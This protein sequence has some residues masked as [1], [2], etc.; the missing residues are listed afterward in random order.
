M[1]PAITLITPTYRP[2][3]ERFAFQRESLERCGIDVEHVA[4]VHSED[5]EL[6]Q[7][8]PHR[9]GLRILSTGQVLGSSLDRRRRAWGVRR[10]NPL[11][12]LV[13][14][15]VHGWMTQQLV[16]LAAHQWVDTDGIIC[17]DSD[18][19]FI[20]RIE[21]ADFYDA[22]GRLHLYETDRDL[23]AEM[24]AWP[25]LSMQFLGIKPTGQPFKKYAHAPA[26]LHR[27]V[28]QDLTAHVEKH[29]QMPWMEAFIRH[30]VYEYSTYGVFARLIDKFKHVV[31]VEPSIAISYWW[32]GEVATLEQTITERAQTGGQ[33]IVL[34]QSNTGRSPA[35]FRNAIERAWDTKRQRS[36]GTR[37]QSAHRPMGIAAE[38]IQ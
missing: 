5:L 16:K 26:C 17:L 31:P 28:L 4:I 21:A 20:D 9:K 19:F 30:S 7:T 1:S 13:R 12:W 22:D 10:L 36:A 11:H 24:A 35:E 15:P 25:S 18:A 8:V 2:D 14:N 23:D 37:P 27:Q 6:F 38:K 3:F 29:R 32:A 33:K 34:V